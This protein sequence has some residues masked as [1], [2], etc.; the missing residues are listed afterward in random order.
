MTCLRDPSEPPGRKPVQCGSVDQHTPAD[1]AH[2]QFFTCNQVIDSSRAQG[3]H[4]RT[5][6][7][8]VQQFVFLGQS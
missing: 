3:Q 1:P 5:L 6:L 4:E 2:G 7:L 8:R